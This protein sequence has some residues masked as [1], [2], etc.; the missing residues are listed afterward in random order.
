MRPFNR[1]PFARWDERAS[2]FRAETVAV[3]SHRWLR[4]TVTTIVSQL[5]LYFVLLVALRAVGVSEDEV[6][7]T[8]ALAGFA[9]IRLLSAV[10]ITPG[11][12]GVVELG[13]TAALSSGLPDSTT[14][15]VAAAVLLFRALTW[16][17]P[18]PL[19]AGCWTFWRSNKSWRRSVEERRAGL[20]AQR[21]AGMMK[22]V[23]FPN[24]NSRTERVI[25]E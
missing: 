24:E 21:A 22:S 18:I 13:L 4:L 6:G 19:G 7:W 23:A 9:F 17:V 1:G 20:D 10:P 2:R 3:L 12:L 5:S 14:N 8:K 16:F 15:Q 11:G 25:S